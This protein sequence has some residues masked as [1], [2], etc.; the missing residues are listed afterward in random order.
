[1]SSAISESGVVIIRAV[2]PDPAALKPPPVVPAPKISS[3]DDVV[4]VEPLLALEPAQLA[5]TST[6]SV[7]TPWYSKMRMSG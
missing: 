4:V 7:L 1:M 6:S 5:P 3:F 2:N